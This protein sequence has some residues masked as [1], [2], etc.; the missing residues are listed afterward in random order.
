L[1]T[2]NPYL[3]NMFAWGEKMFVRSAKIFA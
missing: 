2:A 1:W 3:A